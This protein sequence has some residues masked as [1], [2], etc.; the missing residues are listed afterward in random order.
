V[1]F[2]RA[3][4]GSSLSFIRTPGV[5]AI[6]VED[7][8][9]SLG[10]C[11]M[12]VPGG[13]AERDTTGHTGVCPC[14]A[15]HS[16]PPEGHGGGHDEDRTRLQRRRRKLSP[17]GN[18]AGSL[19]RHHPRSGARSASLPRSACTIIW[20]SGRKSAIQRYSLLCFHQ[21]FNAQTHQRDPEADEYIMAHLKTVGLTDKQAWALTHAAPPSEIKV[22]MFAFD[23]PVPPRIDLGVDLLV[24][25][26][27]RARA[28]PR[29][30]GDVASMSVHAVQDERE[31]ACL[32]CSASK[33]RGG[34]S[35]LSSSFACA[36]GSNLAKAQAVFAAAIKAP[37]CS[38]SLQ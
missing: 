37:V 13:C 22:R 18:P 12:G 8:S 3:S 1:G 28:H 4:A 32:G 21:A 34:R 16:T 33:K 36:S 7:R 9:S 31:R 26:R 20:L 14:P 2:C 10:S 11:W 27:H 35:R 23:A 19:C 24:E 15:P 6:E 17:A 30:F 38:R 25:V 5:P 29:G